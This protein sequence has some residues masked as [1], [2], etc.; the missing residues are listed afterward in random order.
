MRLVIAEQWFT[1]KTKMIDSNYRY[2]EQSTI[3]EY[4]T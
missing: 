3:C 1:L 4:C 2:D